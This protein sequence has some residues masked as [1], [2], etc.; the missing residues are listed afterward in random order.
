MVKA[1]I[2]H[3]NS[4]G[5]RL[6]KWIGYQ[7]S[8]VSSKY[9][10]KYHKFKAKERLKNSKKFLKDFANRSLEEITA[11]KRYKQINQSFEELM[12]LTTQN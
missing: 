6:K 5:S 12:K 2:H 10:K 9:L 7:F 4:I 8:G 3:V 1:E 11:L